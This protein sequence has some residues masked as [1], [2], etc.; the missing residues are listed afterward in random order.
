MVPWECL[1]C[2]AELTGVFCHYFTVLLALIMFHEC[3]EFKSSVE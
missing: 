2:N 3:L 1:L